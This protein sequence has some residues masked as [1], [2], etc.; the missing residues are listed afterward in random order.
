MNVSRYSVSKFHQSKKWRK[1]SK[2]FKN[3]VDC[4]K[5]SE[6]AG[7]ILPVSRYP[8]MGLWQSN[9]VNQCGPCNAKL[10]NKIRWSLQAIKLLGIYAMIKL[11]QYAFEIILIAVL[12]RYVWLDINGNSGTITDQI[13]FDAIEVWNKLD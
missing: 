13:M 7:H 11:L 9:L 4:G 6:D 8:L 10:G 3:C 1:A 12:A 2:A 5:P